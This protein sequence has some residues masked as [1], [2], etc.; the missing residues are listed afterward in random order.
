MLIDEAWHQEPGK[1]PREAYF[2]DLRVD[3][4][5]PKDKSAQS[6]EQLIDG[7]YCDKCNR[8]FISTKVLREDHRR[9]K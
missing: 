2:A 8:A 1:D 4:L 7:F 3:D 5:K 9:Y 6:H